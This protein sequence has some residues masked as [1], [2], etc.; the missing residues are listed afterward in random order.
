MSGI[1]GRR[2]PTS[3]MT[4]TIKS[5]LMRIA[6]MG[7]GG[8]GGY[9]GAR[10]AQAGCDVGFI[11]RGAHLAALRERGLVVKS[12]LGDV[13]LPKVRATDDPTTLGPVDL[14][15]IGVKLWDTEVAVRAISAIVGPA[16]AVLS[17]QNGVQKDD[18]LRRVLG[19]GPIMGGVCYIA[20]TIAQ[21]GVISHTGNMQKLVFGEYNG[22]RSARAEALL[23]ACQRA[24][25]DA[26]LKSRH[27]QSDLGEVRF[28]GWPVSD[29]HNYT[30]ADRAHPHTSPDARIPV[31]YHARGGRRRS[32]AGRRPQRR[33]R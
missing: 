3:L 33:I 22:Q 20:A 10:L 25:I 26:E 5:R 31:G 18:V 11:A 14:I 32:C 24:G 21:P 1:L 6:V 17:L 4:I 30:L 2:H 9:F 28:P 8:V 27:P 7:S 23:E 16:T 15:L 29:Y 19:N 13:N 12:K